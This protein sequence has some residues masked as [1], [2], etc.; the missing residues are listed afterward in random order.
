MAKLGLAS[1]L[2]HPTKPK[3]Q[4]IQGVKWGVSINSNDC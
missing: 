2:L 3:P 4:I 1:P